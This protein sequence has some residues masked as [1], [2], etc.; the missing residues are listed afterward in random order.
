MINQ[1]ESEPGIYLLIKGAIFLIQEI[2]R[3]EGLECNHCVI[4]VG[5]AI[6]SVQGVVDVDVNLEKREAVVDFEEARTNLGKIR[7]AIREAGYEP[8]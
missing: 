6:A 7:E 2:I 1:G 5:R 3:I 4:R 8:L